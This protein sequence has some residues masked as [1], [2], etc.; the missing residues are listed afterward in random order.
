M[1]YTIPEVKIEALRKKVMRI[2]N[3]G[4]NVVFDV[5]SNVIDVKSE[6]YPGLVY[7]AREVEVE[8]FYR[9]NSWEFVGTLEHRENGNII[10]CVDDTLEG[11][12]P[13][14]FHTCEAHCEHCNTI[15]VRKDTYIIHNVDTDEFKQVGRQCLMQYT[16]GLDAK[17][18]AEMMSFLDKCEE[19]YLEDDF[20]LLGGSLPNGYGYPNLKVKRACYEIVSND[21]Y[22]SGGITAGRI[23]K[24]LREGGRFDDYKDELAEIDEF[25]ANMKTDSE[26]SYNAKTMWQSVTGYD[27]RDIALLASLVNVYLKKK[28][29][30]KR[31]ALEELKKQGSGYVG[32]VG[33]RIEFE[34]ANVRT[35]YTKSNSQYSYYA[36]DSYMHEIVTT[37]GNVI[38]WSTSTYLESGMK[39]VATVKSH[40]E[41][42]GVKQTKVTRGRIVG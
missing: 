37:E 1:T 25:V 41:Y 30:E 35:L 31:R 32:E 39:V 21:G 15:R 23:S 27:D 7:K 12:L 11:R 3:K 33:E 16:N 17:V 8:G 14:R 18:C 24:A 42:K 34:I 19:A 26:Y 38:I 36:L 4:V 5:S 22:V 29:E 40:D 9:I 10:R 6:R 20:D 2:A 13:E 28:A